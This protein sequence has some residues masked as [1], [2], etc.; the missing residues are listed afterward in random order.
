MLLKCVFVFILFFVVGLLMWVVMDKMSIFVGKF[1]FVVAGVVYGMF[2]SIILVE[3]CCV[4]GVGDFV[5]IYG[6]IFIVWGFFGFVVFYVV[7]LFYDSYGDYFFVLYV[8]VALSCVF[9]FVV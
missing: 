8:V 1:V 4:V 9:V 6:C 5:C 7:G 2:A 3:V